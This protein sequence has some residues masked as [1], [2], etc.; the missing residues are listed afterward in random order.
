MKIEKQENIKRM[1]LSPRAYLG[2][3]Y[4]KGD[5][6][7]CNVN[8]HAGSNTINTDLPAPP[9]HVDRLAIV[10]LDEAELKQLGLRSGWAS[11]FGE[12]A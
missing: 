5:T 3:R 7:V 9:N 10:T 6:V 2:H 1:E 12:A 8:C 4:R 11:I